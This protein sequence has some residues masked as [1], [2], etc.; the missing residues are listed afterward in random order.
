MTNRAFLWDLDGTLTDSYAVIVPAL[1]DALAAFGLRYERTFVYEYVIRTSVYDLAVFAAEKAG[2]EP[3]PIMDCYTR[4]STGRN[5]QIR[6]MPHAA[7]TL[8]ALHDAGC[9]CFLYTHRGSSTYEL[10]ERNG[11]A[12]YFT[13]IVTNQSGFPRKPEP[14]GI[15]Y[16]MEKHGLDPARSW[17]VGDRRI[18][19]EAA[20]NAGIGSVLFLPPG[21]PGT[22]AGFEDQIVT[23][24]RQI[25]TIE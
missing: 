16:L 23:D 7:E 24:L 15:L 6:A 11:L 3:D 9:P 21:S 20:R 4:I 8:G 12:P 25:L 10:L 18:D 17:Y 1:Q 13:E 22:P 2:L 19:M 5:G 14:D